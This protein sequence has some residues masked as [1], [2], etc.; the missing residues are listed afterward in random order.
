VINYDNQI[1]EIPFSCQGSLSLSSSA[2][3][4]SSLSFSLPKL[5]NNLKK[6]PFTFLSSSKP[7]AASFL[8]S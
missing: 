6:V 3:G 7:A 4:S 2:L 1:L 5:V 8:V